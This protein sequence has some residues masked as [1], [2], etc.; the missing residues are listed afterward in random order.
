MEFSYVLMFFDLKR[1]RKFQLLW[2]PQLMERTHNQLGFHN[3]HLNRLHLIIWLKR[4]ISISSFHEVTALSFQTY[5][6]LAS[7]RG[8]GMVYTVSRI[9]LIVMML[10]S[11]LLIKAG[12]TE[13]LG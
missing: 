3:N 9:N 12:V 10:L 7:L 11:G 6:V 1:K 5:E 8:N 13:M 2:R 4:G